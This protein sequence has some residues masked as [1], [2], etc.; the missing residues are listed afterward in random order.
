MTALVNADLN[1]STVS[2]TFGLA[3]SISPAKH[4][5]KSKHDEDDEEYILTLAPFTKPPKI[6]FGQVKLNQQVERNLLIINPQQ[7]E[8]KLNISNQDL[9]I[10]NMEI[11]IN[12]NTNIDFKIKWQPDKPDNYKYSILFEVTNCA[13]L[14]FLVHAFGVCLSDNKKMPRKPLTMLQPLREKK[15]QQGVLKPAVN[16]DKN[17]TTAS[18]NKVE[19]KLVTNKEN[20]KKQTAVSINKPSISID[21]TFTT[22]SSTTTTNRTRTLLIG[23]PQP[24]AARVAEKKRQKWANRFY[25]LDDENYEDNSNATTVFNNLDNEPHII[26]DIRRQT[27]IISSPKLVKRSFFYST[28]N[29]INE[30]DYNCNQ[31]DYH[32][33]LD[34]CTPYMSRSTSSS[35]LSF[36]DK[37]V[38]FVAGTHGGSSQ[39][40]DDV[41]YSVNSTINNN[42]VTQIDLKMVT[43][44]TSENLAA[45]SSSRD[46]PTISS[47]LK[48]SNINLYLN[49]NTPKY[50]HHSTQ[51]QKSNEVSVTPKL[52]DFVK[53]PSISTYIYQPPDLESTKIA[54]TRL[55]DITAVESTK[56]EII[57]NTSLLSVQ[58]FIS[59]KWSNLNIIEFKR[60]E[61]YITMIQKQWRMKQFRRKLRELR[62]IKTQETINSIIEASRDLAHDLKQAQHEQEE[63]IRREKEKNELNLR[64]IEQARIER[65]ILF[66]NCL[67]RCQ[68]IIRMKR[69]RKHLKELKRKIEEDRM[70]KLKNCVQMLQMKWNYIKF[71]KNLNLLKEKEYQES[72]LNNVLIC[73]R[74]RRMKQFRKSLKQL[75]ESREK[76]IMQY[77]KK[78]HYTIML[79]KAI[80]MKLFRINLHKLIKQRDDFY[81]LQNVVI[82]CQKWFRYKKFRQSLLKLKQE[83]IIRRNLAASKI[84]KYYRMFKFRRQMKLYK[85]SAL[86]IQNWYFN[87]M[88]ERRYYLKLRSS[89]IKIQKIYKLKYQHKVKSV[90]LI[91]SCVRMYLE[92][93]KFTLVK[94][95]AYKIQKWFRT[96]KDRIRYLKLKRS[97]PYIQKKSL[98]YVQ[99]LNEAAIKIQKKYKIYKFRKS[100]KKYRESAITIQRWHREM[101]LRYEF[102]NKKRIIIQIQ[103]LYRRVY[104]V[105]RHSAALRIQSGW[106]T[107]LARKQLV[108]LRQEYEQKLAEELEARRINEAATRIQSLWRGYSIRK[109]TN[110]MLNKI[111]NRLSFYMANRHSNEQKQN[112]LGSRIIKS[113]QILKYPNILIQQLMSTLMELD[114]VTKLSP[115]CCEIF[116]KEGAIEILYAFIG[117]CN[118][119][120]PHM[121]LIKICLQIFINL[122]KYSLTCERLLEPSSALTILT[123]LLQA[124]QTSNPSIFMSVCVLF[125]LLAQNESVKSYLLNQDFFTKKLIQIHFILDRRSNLRMR[126]IQQNQSITS[127]NLPKE[128][129]LN[130]TVVISTNNSNNSKTKSSHVILF[131]IAPEWNLMKKQNVEL[132]DPIGALNYVLNVLEIDPNQTSI[133]CSAYNSQNL[134][135]VTAKTPKK[136]TQPKEK[137]S[138]LKKSNENASASKLKSQ[139][140][141]INNLTAMASSSLSIHIK[142]S[143][144]RRSRAAQKLNLGTQQEKI[145]NETMLISNDLSDVHNDD[146]HISICSNESYR[147][148]TSNTTIKSI[149]SFHSDKPK[150]NSTSI[151]QPSFSLRSNLTSKTISSTS[152]IVKKQTN[153]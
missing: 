146:D 81:K 122:G 19:V 92:R 118:R 148:T 58:E 24:S 145:N 119:S 124:Y 74:F 68:R 69:F 7:F 41:V 115:E 133:T 110:L 104:M 1:P 51:Y 153:S 62:Y 127:N 136:S 5:A 63:I 48:K 107:Y 78:I 143:S 87:Q 137:A 38:V 105:R 116:S 91:Q 60:A 43:S 86:K 61:R 30:N 17:N 83:R 142:Q 54:G 144:T 135:T 6:N 101:S 22:T 56:L 128:Q 106:K 9:K 152:K 90:I 134:D 26:S 32:S 66:K 52:S 23:P 72:L 131:T 12:A 94:Q 25:N 151:I 44:S 113:L 89:T 97:L 33:H 141:A 123:N 70:E 8:V 139:L 75:K 112:T 140:N 130:T 39:N 15:T 40:I 77:N 98:N 93:K 59:Q 111:R 65:D 109:K 76:E 129:V 57:N 28:E 102:I 103:A 147:S 121:D 150:M 29:I 108:K 149:A 67:I 138:T 18:T 117:S 114:K 42:D 47:T 53:T 120:V 27:T 46:S 95:S 11:T 20:L 21:K 79:Q 82:K 45:I 49:A 85:I 71:R 99:K 125:I 3:F 37:T 16:F 14:K 10:N 100:M 73:Q 13:R 84:Q 132:I 50:M 96:K 64:L 34:P 2:A 126:N 36:V 80:R 31:D 55:I 4:K 35:N 88:K